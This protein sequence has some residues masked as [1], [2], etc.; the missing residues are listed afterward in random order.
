MGSPGLP[1]R[2]QREVWRNEPQGIALCTDPLVF[3]M[4]TCLVGV[5]S[6]DER[7]HLDAPRLLALW[8]PQRGVD[9]P[10]VVKE[11]CR[12]GL[13]HW[14]LALRIGHV[15]YKVQRPTQQLG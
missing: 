1:Y 2:W 15:E 7:F 14:C 4:V 3:S 8:E 12:L 9:Q 11:H 6:G 10:Y 5:S 13:G